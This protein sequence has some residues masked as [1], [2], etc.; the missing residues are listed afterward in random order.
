M[1]AMRPGCLLPLITIALLYGGGQSLYTSFK[2]R[3]PTEVTLESLTDK[4]PDAEWLRI[5]GGTLA[6][7]SAAY[8]SAFGVGKAQSVYVP[9]VL[10]SGPGRESIHVVVLTK[11]PALVKFANDAKELGK[12]EPSE[13][14]SL[15]FIVANAQNL[16]VSRTVEGLV[17]FGI[18]STDKE[19]QELGKHFPNLAD[20]A[21]ILKEGEKPS[22]TT[23]IG[24]LL[25]GT[26]LGAILLLR[27]QR[28]PAKGT[29]PPLP[30]GGSGVPPTAPV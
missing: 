30:P 7:M 28:K 21:I 1:Q 20:D 12:K 17:Q 27:S 19:R 11:D 18:E 24:C 15:E 8:S 5:K 3:Q 14:A 22:M 6:A 10:P 4:K 26:T 2:N 13:A 16:K 25:A 9:L 29:P 23:G